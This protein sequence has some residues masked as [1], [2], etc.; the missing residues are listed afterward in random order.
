[1]LSLQLL[2]H[3]GF[4]LLKTQATVVSFSFLPKWCCLGPLAANETNSNISTSGIH[5]K[6]LG[7]S[8]KSEGKAQSQCHK[9]Q[10]TGYSRALGGR[11]SVTHVPRHSPPPPNQGINSPC[12]LALGFS[13]P[14][15]IPTGRFQGPFYLSSSPQD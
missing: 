11:D 15:R 1:M 14:F 4:H 2:V 6:D 7:E 3:T 10:E 9:R 13:A 8:N 12:L 5:Y